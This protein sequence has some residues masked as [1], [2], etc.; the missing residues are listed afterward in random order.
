MGFLFHR[1][2]NIIFGYVSLDDI[3]VRYETML[4]NETH[5][6]AGQGKLW[7]LL[8]II[9]EHFKISHFSSRGLSQNVQMS[10]DENSNYQLWREL[11]TERDLVENTQ[12][13]EINEV[14][15]TNEGFYCFFFLL[16]HDVNADTC[17]HQDAEMKIKR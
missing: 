15:N 3:R 14:P 11:Y 13:N 6:S 7:G 5:I 1:M 9:T 4:W 16:P 10:W 12:R 8:H 2:L 17:T